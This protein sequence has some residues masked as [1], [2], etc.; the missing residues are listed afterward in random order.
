MMSTIVA[1][2]LHPLPKPLRLGK[3]EERERAR[4]FPKKKVVKVKK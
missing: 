2:L 1:S 4:D 3:Q